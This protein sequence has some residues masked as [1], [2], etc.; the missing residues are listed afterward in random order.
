MVMPPP[1]VGSGRAAGPVDR[2]TSGPT[3]PA[4]REPCWSGEDEPGR[5]GRARYGP[6]TG[7]GPRTSGCRPGCTAAC[8][9]CAARRWRCW[10]AS[11]STTSSG[12]SRPAGRG[13]RSRCWP[14]WPARCAWTTDERD[15]FFQLA[16]TAPPRPGRSTCT[17]GQRAAADRPVRRPAGDGAQ[18]QGRRAGLERDVLRAARRLVRAAARAAQPAAAALPARAERPAAQQGR[19][20][21]RGARGHRGPDRRPACGR[22]RAATR[23]TPGWPGCSQDSGGLREF[24]ELWGAPTPA[25]GAATPRP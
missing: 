4:R 1:C 24:R 19:R 25:G 22:P 9:G 6:A 15:Q 2:G 12:S 13:R 11:A 21:R 23:T 3:Q 10:P 18:R 14:R 8:R 7:S 17:C 16:G 20:H 5:A